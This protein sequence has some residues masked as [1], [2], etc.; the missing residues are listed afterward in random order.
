MAKIAELES[1][2]NEDGPQ[3]M[4]ADLLPLP[5]H[6]FDYIFG[7]STGGYSDTFHCQFEN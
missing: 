2:D 1:L 4:A 6:Y 5:C 3:H 7:T